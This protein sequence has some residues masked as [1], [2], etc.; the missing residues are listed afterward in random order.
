MRRVECVCSTMMT[1]EVQVTF[2]PGRVTT[3]V[4]EL[5]DLVPSEAASRQYIDPAG[6][7]SFPTVLCRRLDRFFAGKKISP[8]ANI[9]M[10]A[11]IAIGLAVLTGGWIAFYLFRPG[12]WTFAALY[13]LFAGTHQDGRL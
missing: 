5:A 11:R 9:M 10:W 7:T 8:K 4:P 6:A 3:L 2:E 13:L 12:L 1:A